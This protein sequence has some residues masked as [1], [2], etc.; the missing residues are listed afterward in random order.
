MASEGWRRLTMSNA[1]VNLR[2]QPFRLFTK[3]EAANYCRLPPKK[4]EARCPV[5]PVRITDEDLR[6]DVR[7][8][9]IWIDDL[10]DGAPSDADE[11]VGRLE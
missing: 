6:W 5:R 11:I 9:D 1:T 3:A 4:F 2:V 10:K 8:L 7:D